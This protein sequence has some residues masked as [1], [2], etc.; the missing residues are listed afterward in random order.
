[1]AALGVSLAGAIVFSPLVAALLGA[2]LHAGALGRALHGLSTPLLVSLATALAA[3]VYALL[4]GTPFALLVE[5]VRP[6]L[7]R[8]LWALGLL[9]LMV[10]PYMAAQAS[11]VL[12]GPA[13]RISKPLAWALL[14]DP[15]ASPLDRA[16]F[17]ASPFV[18][19]WPWAGLVLGGC[20]FPLVALAVA[21]AFRRT[22]HRIFE[23]ALMA[24][25]RRGVLAVAARVLA[26]A[27]LGGGLLVFAATLTEFAVPQLLR[28]RTLGEAVYEEIQEGDL[29]AA[30]A[31]GLPLLPL[32]LGAGVLG[33]LVLARSRVA[34]MAGLEG[35]VPRFTG[36]RAGLA[37]EGAAVL[38][39]LLAAAP[40]L[41]AP[42]VSLTWL[43]LTAKAPK[44][45]TAAATYKVLRASGFAEALQGAIEIARDD[46]VRTA[47]LATLAATLALVFAVVVVRLARR[48]PAATLLGALGAGLAV[49]AP[50]VGVGLIVLWN[51][52]GLSIGGVEVL[53]P[54]AVYQSVAVVLFAWWARFLPIAVF[55]VQAALAR[56][57]RELESAAAL[58]GRRALARFFSV[59]LPGAAPGLVAAWLGVYVLSATEFGAT[60]LVAPP[61]RPFLA[62]SVVNLMRR[63]QEFEVAAC[64][65]LLLAVVALPLVPLSLAALARSRAWHRS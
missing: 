43:T 36:R 64:Q 63:G 18:Y 12:V 37:G 38:A 60:V 54:R 44:A 26:P 50:I 35:D 61:G 28:V 59:V 58:A 32:V 31:L 40:G 20:F 13:G 49:P 5:R 1:L 41:L 48:G 53:S 39:T 57:P 24:R 8:A 16:R 23:A 29:S 3:A 62:A 9:V 14:G 30:S 6:S 34:S 45:V 22:D 46:A 65:I 52:P 4:V 17:E 15:L 19:T 7:R 33:A 47:L 11:I 51:R 42:V 56:V 55:L 27:A 21:S 2:D 25:G 10:P